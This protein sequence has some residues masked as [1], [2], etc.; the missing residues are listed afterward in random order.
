VVDIRTIARGGPYDAVHTYLLVADLLVP[1]QGLW[2]VAP[3]S[4]S[5]AAARCTPGQHGPKPL[6]HRL[7]LGINVTAN[8][9]FA[10]SRRD[11][12]DAERFE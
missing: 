8:E 1:W 10:N 6:E 5:S 9:R 2:P 12:D 4:S 11:L 7:E 3:A